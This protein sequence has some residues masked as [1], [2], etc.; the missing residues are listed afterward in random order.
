MSRD[1]FKNSEI[2][3]ELKISRQ[4]VHKHIKRAKEDNIQ[5]MSTG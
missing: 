3:S 2:A 5:L 1:G 4:A